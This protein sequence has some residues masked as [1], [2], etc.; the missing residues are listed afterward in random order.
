[1][2]TSTSKWYPN[3]SAKHIPSRN[4]GIHQCVEFGRAYSKGT[5]FTRNILP[6]LLLTSN[7]FWPMFPFYIKCKHQK[8]FSS[9]SF[10]GEGDKNRRLAKSEL[11][12]SLILWCLS[13][14]L[15]HVLSQWVIKIIP[16]KICWL[17]YPKL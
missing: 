13:S 17:Y 5:E 8:I 3:Y 2:V 11:N 12:K 4:N 1:M 14:I 10:R 15:Q 6:S 9:L 7:N 16:L